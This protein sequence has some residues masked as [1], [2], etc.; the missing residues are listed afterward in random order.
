M[1]E[2]MAGSAPSFLRA[3]GTI[4]PATPLKQQ[5]MVTARN[6]TTLSISATGLF[7]IVA[8]MNIAIAPVTPVSAPLKV[9]NTLSLIRS[10]RSFPDLKS[11]KVIPRK[12]TASACTSAI[13]Q[14][15]VGMFHLNHQAVAQFYKA[16]D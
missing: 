1:L 9:P 5:L 16:D 12:H 14:T 8:K 4:A 10:V 11:P 7:T 6:T 3:N 2:A 15:K 13:S